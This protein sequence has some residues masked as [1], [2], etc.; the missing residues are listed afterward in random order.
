MKSILYI[1]HL[2]F[3][4]GITQQVSAFSTEPNLVEQ[5]QRNLT[6]LENTKNDSIKVDLLL[7]IS[8][9]NSI[10]GKP[11]K[12]IN[13]GLEALEICNKSNIEK[14][15]KARVLNHLGLC[16]TELFDL[17]SALGY[18]HNALKI[19]KEIGNIE[20]IAKLSSN[21]G[22]VYM[23]LSENY[24]ISEL[25][26]R[27]QYISPYM[28]IN[29]NRSI[30]YSLKSATL[31]EEVNDLNRLSHSYKNIF[32]VYEIKGDYKR[33]LEYYKKHSK[34]LISLINDSNSEVIASLNESRKNIIKSET[35]ITRR[36]QQKMR[37]QLILYFSI[38]ILALL[39]LIIL[40]TYKLKRLSKQLMTES[41][42]RNFINQDG[43]PFE[44]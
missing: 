20:N 38:G 22:L 34:T 4:F 26:K 8:I 37:D 43:N 41:K 16:Y 30:E 9:L 40:L 15:K 6:E 2:I 44:D 18:Y 29:L 25:S 12:S 17:D 11:D 19:E 7:N 35:R 21:I 14:R 27:S 1:L 10:I 39:L 5:I 42:N 32:T 24:N 28:N 23:S 36:V 13:Y 31:F 3:S 33:A